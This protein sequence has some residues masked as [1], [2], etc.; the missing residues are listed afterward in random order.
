M[1]FDLASVLKDAGAQMGTGKERLE[2][3]DIGLID[4]DPSSSRSGCAPTRT[5]RG[6]TS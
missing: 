6:G 3:I 5:S 2:Y 4:E 1:G